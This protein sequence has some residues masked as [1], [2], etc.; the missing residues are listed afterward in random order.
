[1]TTITI[2]SILILTFASGESALEAAAGKTSQGHTYALIINGISKDPRDRAVK[3]R[4]LGDCSAYLRDKAQIDPNRL[5]VLTAEQSTAEHVERA[6]TALASSLGPADRF[7]FYYI[8][9]A[10]AVGRSLRLNVAG[11]DITG[12]QLGLWLNRIET[13]TQI[14]VLDCPCAGLACEKMTKPGRILLLAATETQTYGTRFSLHFIPA[15]AQQE[16]DVDESG[17]VSV[18]EA[19]AAA[20]RDIEQWYRDADILATETPTLE[21]NADGVPSEQPWRY[22]LD[23]DDGF[24]AAK[25]FMVQP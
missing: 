1:M 11:P 15:L 21:D 9:Q 6:M 7:I 3:S 16:N 2:L 20:A 12:E 25:F 4:L 22:M 5:T 19:F 8:G 14:V 10:N 17:S 13:N 23:G 18:L 24:L